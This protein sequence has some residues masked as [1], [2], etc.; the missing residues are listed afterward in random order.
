MMTMMMLMMMSWRSQPESQIVASQEQR[1]HSQQNC[2]DEAMRVVLARIGRSI[3]EAPTAAENVI[4]EG[5][6]EWNDIP[7]VGCS[8]CH[9]QSDKKG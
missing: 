7:V 8:K 9:V 6:A 1:R 4:K 3:A 2:F 5:T